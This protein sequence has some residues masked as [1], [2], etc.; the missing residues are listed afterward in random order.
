MLKPMHKD[1]MAM[2]LILVGALLFNFEL[3]LTIASRWLA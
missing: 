3:L 2:A 1:L